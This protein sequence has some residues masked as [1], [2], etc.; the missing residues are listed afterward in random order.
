MKEIKEFGVRWAA[1][2]RER[3]LPQ[4]AYACCVNCSRTRRSAAA[5][6]ANTPAQ[7][8]HSRAALEVVNTERLLASSR[9][10]AA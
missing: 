1:D 4:G 5:G 10:T 3:L 6:A 7:Q 8:A 9:A 2:F